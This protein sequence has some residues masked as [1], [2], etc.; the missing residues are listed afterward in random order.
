MLHSSHDWA[1]K[2][3]FLDYQINSTATLI[4]LN[5]YK[6]FCPEIPFIYVS[7]NKVYGDNPNKIKLIEKNFVLKWMMSLFY[8]GGM[9]Q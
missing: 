6:N 4:L 5:A 3:M 9:N 2:D 7:T 1:V 8:K